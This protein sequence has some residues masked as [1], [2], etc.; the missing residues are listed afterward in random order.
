MF[1]SAKIWRTHLGKLGKSQYGGTA[2]CILECLEVS[3]AKGTSCNMSGIIYSWLEGRSC[4]ETD[5]HTIW[6]WDR[7][8]DEYTERQAVHIH[9]GLNI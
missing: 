9:L 6:L 3:A 5:M 1:H 4:V 8:R 7:Q 2:E